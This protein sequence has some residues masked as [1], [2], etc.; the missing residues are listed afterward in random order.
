MTKTTESLHRASNIID[1]ILARLPAGPAREAFE[2]TVAELVAD[3]EG[4]LEAA[5]ADLAVAADKA[6]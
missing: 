3:L 4:G 6:A 1:G 2:A 5:V